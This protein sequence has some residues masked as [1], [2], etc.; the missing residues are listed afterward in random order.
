MN[1]QTLNIRGTQMN[2]VAFSDIED[3]L[4]DKGID[5]N[6]AFSLM[7]DEREFVYVSNGFLRG[8]NAENLEFGEW[9]HYFKKSDDNTFEAEKLKFN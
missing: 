6:E 2:K 7:A 8:L 9:H 1:I 5:A 4:T 3:L